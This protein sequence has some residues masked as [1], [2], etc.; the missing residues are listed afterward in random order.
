MWFLGIK[1][2]AGGGQPQYVQSLPRDDPR[3]ITND[4]REQMLQLDHHFDDV[5]CEEAGK[6]TLGLLIHTL[7]GKLS[8]FN[9]CKVCCFFEIQY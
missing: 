3:P 8:G 6:M 1:K 9:N 2:R 7:K 5:R 4:V